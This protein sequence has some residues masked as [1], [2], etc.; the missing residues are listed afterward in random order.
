M[1][2]SRPSLRFTKVNRKP[3]DDDWDRE[4][5]FPYVFHTIERTF[6]SHPNMLFLVRRR[7]LKFPRSCL[8]ALDEIMSVLDHHK[9][10][11]HVIPADHSQDSDYYHHIAGTPTP[12]A[13][14]VSLMSLYYN[15]LYTV[16]DPQYQRTLNR[17]ASNNQKP[18]WIEP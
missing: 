18:V 15:A 7:M 11:V 6:H 2:A 1:S 14:Y 17:E 9:H 4:N 12:W 3:I 8:T 16:P 5:E 10:A 13:L